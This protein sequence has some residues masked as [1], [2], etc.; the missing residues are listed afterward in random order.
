[1]R[2]AQAI[3]VCRDRTLWFCDAHSVIVENDKELSLERSC[4]VQPFHCNAIDDR[5]ISNERDGS[6]TIRLVDRPTFTVE[7]IAASHTDSSWDCSPC[8]T[9]SEEIEIGFAWFWETRHSAALSKSWQKMLSSGQKFMGVALMTDIKEQTVIRKVEDIVHRNSEFDDA[10][11]GSQMS[12][13]LGDLLANS[14][15]NFGANLDKVGRWKSLQV[16]W[17][18]DGSKEIHR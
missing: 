11:I 6:P 17:R 12:A 18:M 9:N 15:A 14:V 3:E 8:M 13:A 2:E 4:I 5:C 1:M 10:E 7:R 16:G